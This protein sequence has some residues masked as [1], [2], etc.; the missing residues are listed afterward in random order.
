M[1]K[2]LLCVL[3]LLAIFAFAAQAEVEDD[4]YDV[5]T[6][7]FSNFGEPFDP[8]TVYDQDGVALSVSQIDFEPVDGYRT[9]IYISTHVVNDSDYDLTLYM[10]GIVN[11]RSSSAGLGAM[12]MYDIDAHS[13]RD[14]VLD[15]MRGRESDPFTANAEDVLNIEFD[16]FLDFPEIIPI[17]AHGNA[18]IQEG[19]PSF[20]LGRYISYK[21]RVY[22]GDILLDPAS[23]PCVYATF[24]ED[25]T[26]VIEQYEPSGALKFYRTFTWEF[27]SYASQV[28]V[29][30]DQGEEMRFTYENGELVIDVDSVT[31]DYFKLIASD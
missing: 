16:I 17:K 26:G 12:Y 3:L 15:M 2:V 30:T 13:E 10:R 22:A 1:K 20:P 23:D 5:V 7:Y 27:R 9:W 8:V 21:E 29:L 28:V 31:K 6:F 4:E 11:M 24:D 25:G 19:V 14:V 18:I